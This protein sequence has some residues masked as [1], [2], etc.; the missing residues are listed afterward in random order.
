MLER[1]QAAALS[2]HPCQIS[3]LPFV[4]SHSR[5]RLRFPS[6]FLLFLVVRS[7]PPVPPSWSPSP[8]AP[9]SKPQPEPFRF[10][11]TALH[12]LIF[13]CRCGR[14]K[15]KVASAKDTAGSCK[16]PRH[17]SKGQSALPPPPPDPTRNPPPPS[18]T[19]PLS[20]TCTCPHLTPFSCA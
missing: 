19:R 4:A 17:N 13:L 10:T 14:P 20:P 5:M 3:Y 18:Q 2:F 12:R 6:C 11:S 15:Q 1:R 9:L 7:P 16:G 8:H